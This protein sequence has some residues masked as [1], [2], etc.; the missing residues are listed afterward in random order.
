MDRIHPV[1][2]PVEHPRGEEVPGPGGVHHLTDR[3]RGHFLGAVRG[4]DDAAG[5]P[6][7][8]DDEQPCFLRRFEGRGVRGRP[9]KHGDLL[10]VA[11]QNVDVVHQQV[12]EFALV[13]FDAERIRQ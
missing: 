12:Q 4:Q 11:Q 8:H 10:L 1:R 13:A 3:R 7:R 2:Q 6:T 5:G 9:E